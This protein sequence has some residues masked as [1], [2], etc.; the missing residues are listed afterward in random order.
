MRNPWKIIKVGDKYEVH[1]EFG[2]WKTFNSRKDAKE[3]INNW[4]ADMKSTIKTHGI[5]SGGTNL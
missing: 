1:N 4:M 2:F 5:Y 3:F